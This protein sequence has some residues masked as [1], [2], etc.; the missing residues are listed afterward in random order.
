METSHQNVSLLIIGFPIYID[1][2]LYSLIAKN[3]NFYRKLRCE[4]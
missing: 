2:Y 1:I 4:K 3:L